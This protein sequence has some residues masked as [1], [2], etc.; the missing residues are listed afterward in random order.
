LGMF[1][2]LAAHPDGVF[3]DALAIALGLHLPYVR[4]WCETACALELLDYEPA[5]GYQF[6]PHMDELLGQPDATFYLGLFPAVHLQIERDYARYSEL[7]RTGGAFPYQEHDEPFLHSVAAALRT[8]PRIVIDALLPALPHLH[9]LLQGD[10]KILDVGCGGGYAMVEFAERFPNVTCLG[11]DVEP[12]S[13]GMANELIESRGLANRVSAQLVD[14][15]A[16][17]ETMTGAFDLATMFLVLHEIRPDLKEHVLRQCARALRPGGQLLIFDE[18]YPSGPSQFRNPALSMVV[19]AQ[20]FELVWGNIMNTR[21]EIHALLAA[22]DL[23]VRNET[24][25]SRFYVVVAE[26]A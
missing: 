11:L 25:F 13:I 7:F 8:L 10:A 1:N 17:P 5:S 15:E 23:R 14:G 16:W 24:S 26:K 19:T 20:W 6:A 12:T 3:P 22:Q 18:A 9:A 21:E 4:A 2:H